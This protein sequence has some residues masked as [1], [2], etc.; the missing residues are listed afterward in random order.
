MNLFYVITGAICLFIGW[1]FCQANMTRASISY[2]EGFSV[3][4]IHR[5]RRSPVTISSLITGRPFPES[6][7]HRSRLSPSSG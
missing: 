7:V 4:I 2:E 3:R 1:Q 6:L 5:E